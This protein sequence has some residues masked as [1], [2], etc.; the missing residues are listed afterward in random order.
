MNPSIRKVFNEKF[1]TE[2]Y[3]QFLSKLNSDLKEPVPFRVAETPVFLTADFRDKLISAGNDIVHTI[4]KPNFKELTERAIPDFWRV[5]N[6]ND[7]PHFIALDFGIC[8]DEQ[9]NIVPKLIELQGFPSLYSFQVHLGDTYQEVYDT[10]ADE[11]IFFGGLKEESYLDLLKKTILGPYQ[12]DEVV[13][14]DVNAPE[15]KTA[16]DFYLTQKYIGT[17]VVS[18]SDLIQDGKKL[19]YMAGDQKKLIKRIYNRLIFDEIAGDPDIFTKVADIR[20]PLE[21]EWITHPNWFYRVSKFT[22]PFLTGNYIP[23]TQFLHLLKQIPAN[24]ENYVLKPLFS[25]A[26]QGVI[27]DISKED[28]ETITDPENWILQEKVN[29]EAVVQSPEGGV[30]AEIRLLYLWPDGDKKP[31]LAI[32]LARL[33]RGKMIGV[34]YNKDYNW[35]GGTVAF[36]PR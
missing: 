11:T 6:E 7:H 13:L 3:S 27:I 10:P 15:Q 8:K 22:M 35:V 24:L 34:R 28:I 5:S 23:K 30:K 2:K 4:L 26:G 32:N 12:S 17:P 20:Q 14:M 19:Y 25:F 18:L 36:M 1:S 33:S 16:V 29:Y 31:T 9:G 21:V